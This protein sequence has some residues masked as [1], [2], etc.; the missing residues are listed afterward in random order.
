MTA[1]NP[2]LTLVLGLISG[3]GLAATISAL[4]SGA[5]ARSK[6][7]RDTEQARVEIMDSLWQQIRTATDEAATARRDATKTRSELDSMRVDVDAL[8]DRVGALESDQGHLVGYVTVI[9]AGV[10]AGTVPPLPPMP[11][12]VAAILSHVTRKDPP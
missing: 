8:L 1:G 3:G 6:D 2:W 5:S 4:F 12:T 7:H 11:P 10:E 9:I